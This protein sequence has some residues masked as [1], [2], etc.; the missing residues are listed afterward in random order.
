VN[1]LYAFPPARD[2]A[3]FVGAH[4][5][6]RAEAVH[7]QLEDIVVTVESFRQT[8]RSRRGEL[9]EGQSAFKFSA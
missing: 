6:E 5:R 2:E 8:D 1:R 9:R 3:R 7:L 4:V